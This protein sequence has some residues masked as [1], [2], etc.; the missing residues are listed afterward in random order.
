MFLMNM[1][2]F[3]KSD[4]LTK[5]LT[6]YFIKGIFK[7]LLLVIL[8]KPSQLHYLIHTQKEQGWLGIREIGTDFGKAWYM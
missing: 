2:S 6:C 1:F 7:T 8:K 4:R 3:N 5:V